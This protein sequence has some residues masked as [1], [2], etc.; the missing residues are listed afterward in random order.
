MLLLL[1]LV[2]PLVVLVV[3]VLA[4]L[5]PPLLTPLLLPL[6]VFFPC[7]QN[8][9]GIILFIRMANIVHTLRIP[10]LFALLL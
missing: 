5:P 4:L 10:A 1:L 2:L 3:L 7:L 6:Q 8:I 9:F